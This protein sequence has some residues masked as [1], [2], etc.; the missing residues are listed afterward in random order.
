MTRP[1]YSEGVTGE[2]GLILILHS[3]ARNGT[4]ACVIRLSYLYI[5]IDYSKF[6]IKHAV[7]YEYG[8]SRVCFVAGCK[9]D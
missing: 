3:V 6:T 4:S 5:S 7:Q 1:K 9:D 8:C 2:V